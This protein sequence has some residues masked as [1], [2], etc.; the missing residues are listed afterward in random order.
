MS[1]SADEPVPAL[2]VA[3]PLATTDKFVVTQGSN[4]AVTAPGSAVATLMAT[5]LAATF[6]AAGAAAAV[7]KS[8]IGLGNVENTALSTWAGSTSIVNAGTITTGTWAATTIAIAHGG[9]GATS[10]GA[11][12]TALG[13]APLASPTFTGVA[14]IPTAAIAAHYGAWTTATDAATVTLD[15]SVTDKYTLLLTSA[16][17]GTRIIAFSNFAVGQALVLEAIQPASGGPCA[18]TFSSTIRW[19][20]GSIPTLATGAN[21]ADQIVIAKRSDGTY[22]GAGSILNF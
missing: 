8:S 1:Y 19:A 16:V 12:L 14:T 11:A 10:A 20:G 13:A 3:A 5:A 4:I 7:S 15:L 21:Q 9:T 17:G 2:T 6:D 22:C 18:F